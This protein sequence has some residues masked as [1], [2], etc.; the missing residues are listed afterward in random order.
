MTGFEPLITGL[1][2]LA[3]EVVKDTAK[4]E[5]GGRLAKWLSTDIGKK[6]EQLFFRASQQYFTNYQERHGKLKVV[7]VR[8]DQPIEL[9]EIYTAV[10]VLDRSALRYFESEERLHD[11]FRQSGQRGLGFTGTT[12]ADGITIANRQPYLLVLGGPGVGKSTFLRKVGLEALKRKRGAFQPNCLPVFLELQRFKSSEVTIEQLI[13]NEFATC[14]FPEPQAFTQAMLKKG[15]LLILLDG[16]DE[17]PKDVE[18]HVIAQIRDFVDL[19]RNNRFIAS[20]RIAAYKGG[21]PRFKDVAMAAFED[22]Q[23]QQFIQRWFRSPKDQEE[24]T[25]DRCWELLQR[26]D[27]AAAKD[28]AQTPLLLTL[29]CTVYDKSL[30][31]PKNRS[32]LYGEALDVLLKE[33]AA[34]KRIQRDPIYQEL[35]L[36]LERELLADIAYDS[37]AVNQL[38]FNKR[39]TTQR[40]K[41]FLVNNLNAPKHLDSEKVLEAI[42]VQQGI[43]VERAREVYS[44]S[45][46]TFQEY[47]TAQYIVDNQ[48]IEWLVTNHLTDDRWREV[49]VLVAGLMPGRKGADDLLLMMADE[50]QSRINISK[51]KALLH[52]VKAT[53]EGS[54]GKY[55]PITKR[56][57]AIYLACALD[58]IRTHTQAP[59]LD[60]DLDL[61]CAL[62]YDLDRDLAL[63]LALSFARALTRAYALALGYDLALALALTRALAFTRALNRANIFRTINLTVLTERLKLFQSQVPDDNQPYEVRRAFA[64]QI[65]QLWLDTLQLDPELLQWSEDELSILAS[66]LYANEL[67]VRCKEAAVRVTPQVWEG[68]E[69]RMLTVKDEVA[70]DE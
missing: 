6:A 25:A 70:T 21:F 4:E 5:S 29:L 56:A 48:Q 13:L 14:G 34:E 65:R 31:F 69:G 41:A 50:A 52:W 16:L 17:V 10:Q 49:F 23:I 40:I 12:K 22:A 35:S 46:L 38:F 27:Y 9:D 11:W 63:A 62:A 66:Y 30:D 47:L 57:T 45:H 24:K 3:I 33:W 53:T 7:C 55:S 42:E 32:A 39:D 51:L 58:R 20:C 61:A 43:L 26:P 59:A 15:K 36:E 64:D 44:F 2:T 19:H 67:M 54:E 8:M 68:I 37:F 1:A 60:C 28:L 18:D